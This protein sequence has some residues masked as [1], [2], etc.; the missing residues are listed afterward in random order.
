[1]TTQIRDTHRPKLILALALYETRFAFMRKIAQ[2]L[3][4]LPH[5]LSWVIVFGILLAMLSPGRMRK[6]TWALAWRGRMLSFKPPEI[7]V[8][9]VVVRMVASVL[10]LAESLRRTSPPSSHR[11]AKAACR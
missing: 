1:M 3:S 4:Y 2:N 8:T 6:L 9:A 10:A 5:F 11:L 7:M